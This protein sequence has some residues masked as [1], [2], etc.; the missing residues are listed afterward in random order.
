M[1]VLIC[2]ADPC[3]LK[4]D[5]AEGFSERYSRPGEICREDWS[6]IVF[7]LGQFE[8]SAA[9]DEEKSKEFLPVF[10][11]PARFYPLREVKSSSKET[12]VLGE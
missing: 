9:H 10:H 12:Y 6:G 8:S 4:K 7:F 3:L 2:T 1:P 5:K 11:Q